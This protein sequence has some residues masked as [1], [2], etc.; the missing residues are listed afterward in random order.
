MSSHL[1]RFE[2]DDR[3]PVEFSYAIRSIR[4]STIDPLC[5]RQQHKVTRYRTKS[6]ACIYPDGEPPSRI[7]SLYASAEKRARSVGVDDGTRIF[8]KCYSQL[9]SKRASGPHTTLRPYP[10]SGPVQDSDFDTQNRIRSRT[11]KARK[12]IRPN[13]VESAFVVLGAGFV[14]IRKGVDLFIA[15][16][17]A[18]LR[19]GS[20]RP[21]RF[22]WIGSGYDPDRELT[23]STYL[24]EQIVRSGVQDH[25][26]VLDQV[27]DLEPAYTMADVFYL[28]SR[29]DPLPNVAI[30]AAMRRIPIVCFEGATGIAD[31]LQGDPSPLTTSCRTSI[32]KAL[33]AGSSPWRT[34]NPYVSASARRPGRWLKQRLMLNDTSI[35]STRSGNWRSSQCGNSEVILKPCW[36]IPYSTRRF[37]CLRIG[38][39]LETSRSR[40]FWLCG[41][42][43]EMR[44]GA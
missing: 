29:F 41:R 8:D 16:A 24:A 15:T 38:K 6:C 34:T 33:R 36:T 39:K 27:T 43:S 2:A 26:V 7:L 4:N 42:R 5:D 20:R 14:H 18:A 17:A 35:K 30:D 23:Y 21:I 28:S 9:F 1:I 25:V 31:V 32:P 22:V 13:G 11:A 19:I 3:N 37:L 44:L 12:A 10:P 40:A